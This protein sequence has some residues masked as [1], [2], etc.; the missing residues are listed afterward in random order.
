MPAVSGESPGS[1]TTVGTARK[2][3]IARSK[4][5]APTAPRPRRR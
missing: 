4:L 3:A 2:T 5:T 1:R